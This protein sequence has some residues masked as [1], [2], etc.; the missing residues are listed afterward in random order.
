MSYL[1]VVF[2]DHLN[3]IHLKKL[4]VE[5]NPLFEI[6]AVLV[7]LPSL[8]FIKCGSP[9]TKVISNDLLSHVNDGKLKITVL[10]KYNGVLK[11]PTFDELNSTK[12]QTYIT[13]SNKE[14]TQLCGKLSTGEI[15]K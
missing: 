6:P 10:P 13:T 14:I 4:Y 8:V 9:H 11:A 12:I 2:P 1:S 15:H 7:Q 5:E 3:F